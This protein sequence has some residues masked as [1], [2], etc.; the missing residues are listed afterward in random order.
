MVRCS[1]FR[2]SSFRSVMFLALSKRLL[3]AALFA[4]AGWWEFT[5][6]CKYL[7]VCV[8][9]LKTV[10]LRIP[11]SL[12]VRL[13]SRK[14]REPSFSSSMVNLM[15]GRTSLRWRSNGS[16][17]SLC[18]MQQV[19]STY[20]FQNLGLEGADS[21]ASSSKNSMYRLVTTTET[22]ELLAA[23]LPLLVELTTVAEVG[24]FQT[25][26]EE[27]CDPLR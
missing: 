4:L 5:C 8:R 18:I 16:T 9:F 2:R 12:H 23:P 19:S 13:V 15:V 1:S 10:T 7:S 6:K 3:T 27:L 26:L 17:A 14:G 11:S 21:R 22:G 24:G 25:E 20:R